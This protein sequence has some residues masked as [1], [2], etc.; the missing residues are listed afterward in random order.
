MVDKARRE[1][2]AGWVRNCSDGSVEAVVQGGDKAVESVIRWA[3]NGPSFCQV[4]RVEVED[5]TGQF[6]RFDIRF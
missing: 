1:G 3:K 4:D 2:V 5:A 6:D